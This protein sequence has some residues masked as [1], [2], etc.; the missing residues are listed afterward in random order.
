MKLMVCIRVF[1][2]MMIWKLIFHKFEKYRKPDSN[3][4]F[5]C[6]RMKVLFPAQPLCNKL[7]GRMPISFKL[8]GGKAGPDQPKAQNPSF[9]NNDQFSLK[10]TLVNRERC[11]LTQHESQFD[12]ILK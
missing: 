1:K 4:I 9:P 8:A 7:I 2:F 5:I 6:R 11:F 10:K 12:P 3:P